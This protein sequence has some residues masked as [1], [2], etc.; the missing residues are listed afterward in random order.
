[1]KIFELTYDASYGMPDYGEADL[2][3]LLTGW[4]PVVYSTQPT[5]KEQEIVIKL[6]EE[7]Q[8]ET[9]PNIEFESTDDES[10]VSSSSTDSGQKLKAVKKGMKRE[11][12][13]VTAPRPMPSPIRDPNPHS[14]SSSSVASKSKYRKG[15]TE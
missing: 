12:S 3:Q 7:L 14:L 1:M 11:K 8:K 13:F 5:F 6:L 2:V 4:N 9:P 10:E 15:S